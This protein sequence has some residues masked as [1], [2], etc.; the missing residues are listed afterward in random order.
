MFKSL[1]PWLTVSLALSLVG[2]LAGL[3]SPLGGYGGSHSYSQALLP[4]SLAFSGAWVA[5]FLLSI[6]ILRWR[7][8][9]LLVGAP[10]ALF[11]PMLFVLFSVALADCMAKHPPPLTSCY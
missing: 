11:W 4:A 9:W 6:F 5:T 8:L 7:A 1:T 3:L 2:L 10:F